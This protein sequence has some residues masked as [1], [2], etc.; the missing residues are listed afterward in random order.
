[1]HTGFHTVFAYYFANIYHLSNLFD[2]MAENKVPTR[3]VEVKTYERRV[4]V[5]Y[6]VHQKKK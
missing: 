1:M 2:S 3:K 6:H 4:P 5:K